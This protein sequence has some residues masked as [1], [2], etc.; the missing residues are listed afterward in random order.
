MA[1]RK[2]KVVKPAPKR[3]SL[4]KTASQSRKKGP[5][6]YT[7]QAERKRRQPTCSMAS[8]RNLENE[9]TIEENFTGLFGDSSE[10]HYTWGK[11]QTE[12]I[13]AVRRRSRKVPQFTARDLKGFPRGFFGFSEEVAPEPIIANSPDRSPFLRLPLE[14]REKI[15]ARSLILKLPIILQHD[16]K[17]V[18]NKVFRKRQNNSLIF[19][20]KQ[21]NLETTSFLYKNNV[22]RTILRPPPSTF[23]HRDVVSIDA[24]FLPLF[25]NV[26][27]TCEKENYHLGWFEKACE[28]VG[29]LAE[30]G[31]FLDSLTIVTFPQRVGMSSTAVGLEP[32][33]VTFA[34][35]FYAGG[36]LMAEIRKLHCKF[37]NIVVKKIDL[38]D[39]DVTDN[40]WRVLIS[41]DMRDLH[42]A[43]REDGPLFNEESREL[44][45]RRAEVVERELLGLKDRFEEVFE[46]DERA[47]EED[48]CLVLNRDDPI[49]HGM[50]LAA[51]YF[52]FDDEVD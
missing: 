38:D 23:F 17:V 24:K 21:I 45:R 43:E 36:Q 42:A 10:S 1:P 7:S 51:T 28:S 44:A 9:E 4:P 30:A 29:K 12:P 33:P 8:L 3:I 27:L 31:A 39:M 25:R 14:V 2:A 32:H 13:A 34:D 50:E 20:C 5:P 18:E 22:F 16:W 37:L 49:D 26:I 35:F 52:G 40:H 11:T 19:L 47:A 6:D 48:K 46:D 41:V 15:Y